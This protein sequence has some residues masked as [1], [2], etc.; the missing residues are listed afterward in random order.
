MSKT[1]TSLPEGFHELEQFVEYWAGETNDIRWDHRSRADMP[2]IQAFYDAMLARSEDA[3]QHLEKFDMDDLP[4]EEKRLFCLVLSL[5]HAS[6]AVELHEQPRA[7]E[8]PFPHGLHVTKG[9]WP[10]GGDLSQPA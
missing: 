4:A 9:P 3:I 5:V 7:I 8:S 10:L 2:E 1:E 6:I